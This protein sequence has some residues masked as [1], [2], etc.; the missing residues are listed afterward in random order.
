MAIAL[1]VNTILVAAEGSPLLKRPRIYQEE[2]ILLRSLCLIQVLVCAAILYMEIVVALPIQLYILYKK[3]QRYSGTARIGISMKEV[4]EGLTARECF[5]CIRNWFTIQFRVCLLI[6]AI[7]S[8]VVSPLFAAFN[9]MLFIYKISTLRTFITAITMNGKQLM[10]TFLLGLI[11]VYL[12]SIVGFLLFP[13]SFDATVDE[14]ENPDLNHCATLLQCFTY[15]MSQGL[16]A[17]GGVGD[18]M[19]PWDFQ[20]SNLLSRV[21]Y[22]MTFYALVTV[23]FLNIMF[24]IIIDTFGQMRDEKREKEI[25]MHT[26]CFIC[27][28]DADVLEKVSSNGLCRMSVRNTICGCICF[29]APP[30]PQ[31][32]QRVHRSGK[33]R[34]G[35]DSEK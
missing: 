22:E 15:I 21:T 13:G 8:V 3:K 27:G 23:V 1:I 24:G 34:A 9:L 26:V 32:S 2:Q 19:Q 20:D 4:Y 10:L 14:S 7:L 16:R 18:V 28:L 35:S 29:Y 17:G 25:D 31:G 33:L 6:F 12:F 30:P 5:D 11:M